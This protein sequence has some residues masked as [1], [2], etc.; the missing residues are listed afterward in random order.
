MLQVQHNAQYC[1]N[2]T[3][4]LPDFFPAN[5]VRFSWVNPFIFLTGPRRE[6]NST[7]VRMLAFDALLMTRWYTPKIM[8]YMFAIIANDPSRVIR[9]HV[10][11]NACHSL[12]LLVYMGEMKGSSKDPE[13]LL[14]EEDG[15]VPEKSKESKKS[16]VELTLKALRKDK[17]V[18]KND[19][20]REFLMPL[21][22]WVIFA[23]WTYRIL[24][25]DARSCDADQQARWAVL[26]LAD[27]VLRGGEEA[28]PKITIQ[29]PPT[30][31]IETPPSPM[32]RIQPVAQRILKTGP[33]SS[34]APGNSSTPKIKLVP[35]GSH[36][37]SAPKTPVGP[38]RKGSFVIPPPKRQKPDKDKK[39]SAPRPQT[40]GIS[41][42]DLGACRNALKKLQ[43]H[44]RAKLFLKPVDPV[45]DRAPE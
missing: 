37:E 17:E 30:P 14:I 33:T 29:L 38:Q 22:L 21:L 5:Q 23:I 3:D 7:Q 35:L 8:K 4:R 13:T 34:P 27:L 45:R 12:A 43:A 15:S 25:L 28:P 2:D 44:R 11:I 10:A 40:S 39:K 16:D 31:V 6:G 19:I 32:V 18:G 42:Y 1:R 36:R 26:K 9:R 24:T 20:L 41:V